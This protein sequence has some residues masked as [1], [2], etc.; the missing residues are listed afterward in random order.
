MSWCWSVYVFLVEW[1]WCNLVV[2]MMR[3]N[4]RVSWGCVCFVILMLLWLGLRGLSV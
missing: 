3:W 2:V 4:I 1:L